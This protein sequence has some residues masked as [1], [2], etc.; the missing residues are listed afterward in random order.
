MKVWINSESDHEIGFMSFECLHLLNGGERWNGFVQP[1]FNSE[2]LKEVE[3]WFRNLWREEVTNGYPSELVPNWNE[4][5]TDLGNDEYV[6]YGWVWEC[7]DEEA[8]NR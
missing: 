3:K 7:D 5:Y 8:T 1:V 2:Q 4:Q 6:I